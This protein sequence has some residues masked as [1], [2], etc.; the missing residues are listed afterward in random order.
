[1]KIFNLSYNEISFTNHFDKLTLKRKILLFIHYIFNLNVMLNNKLD[2]D[3][4]KILSQINS[5]L[6]VS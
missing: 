4:K 1:M 5:F 6:I 3:Y 2:Q